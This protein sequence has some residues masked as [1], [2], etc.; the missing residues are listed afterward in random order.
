MQRRDGRAPQS[1]LAGALPVDISVEHEQ[2]QLLANGETTSHLR[3][4]QRVSTND[5]YL[6]PARC[7]PNLTIVGD[8]VVDRV[9][10]DGGLA[11]GVRVLI[12]EAWHVINSREVFLCAGAIH[13]PAILLRSGI[14]PADDLRQIGIAPLVNAPGVGQNLGE[15]TAADLPV[16]GETTCRSSQSSQSGF[17]RMP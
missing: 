9:E 7:R 15:H 10:L 12:G 14:G 5:A 11:R 2:H 17:T 4:E 13:S 1:A 16:P 8:A 6:E 3:N